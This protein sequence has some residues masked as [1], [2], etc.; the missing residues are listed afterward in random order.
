M[1]IGDCRPSPSIYRNI[2]MPTDSKHLPLTGADAMLR[3]F[4]REVR[5][6]HSASHASQLVLR[7][8]PGLD[9]T[10]LE[11]LIARTAVEVPILRA[12]I[13]RPGLVGAPIYDL[14]SSSRNPIPPLRIHDAG[15]AA[16]PD[17]FPPRVFAD[18][19]NEPFDGR[20]G[21]LLRF[22]LVR[23]RDGAVDL[24]LT[25]LHMLL[26][27]TGSETFVRALA[28]VGAGVRDS[29]GLEVGPDSPI[30]SL[31]FR[32]R[33]DKARE[34]QSF[35][36]A[37]ADRP[38]RSPAGPLHRARQEVDYRVV[39]FN[40]EETTRIVET[41]GQKAGFLTP[42][43]FYMA[44]AIRAHHRLFVRRGTVPESYVVP[45]PVNIRSKGQEGAI[46]RTHVSMIWFQVVPETVECFDELVAELKRQRHHA[47]RGGLVESGVHAIEFARYLPAE[48]FARMVRRTF[49]GELCSFFFAFTG[50]F[51]PGVETFLG[52][53]VRNGFHVPAVPPSPGSC[54]AMSIH[55]G[56]LNMTHVFQ[57]GALSEEEVGEFARDMRR[58][59][60]GSWGS[61]V[62]D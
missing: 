1:A 35:L 20:R 30:A 19:M 43:M 44:V 28:E 42:V 34:W 22:D 2:E 40:R 5:R 41:A 33:G 11:D 47:I 15:G 38:P 21:K 29:V 23:R 52:A 8:G 13:R 57:R 58:E 25:W 9:V 31:S 27:G 16:L 10:A 4:D 26:D 54:A 17:E 53:E 3:A 36:E 48:L 59:L 55:D 37:F 60:M 7:L 61:G 39:T 56:R 50:D 62:G 24:A 49:K 18:A 51:L 46:F 45:L 12:S 14:G 32:E 6:Y